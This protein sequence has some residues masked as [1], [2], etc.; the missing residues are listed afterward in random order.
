M[1]NERGI[2]T[3]NG[4]EAVLDPSDDMMEASLVECQDRM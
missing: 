1:I 3:A 2:L 4:G